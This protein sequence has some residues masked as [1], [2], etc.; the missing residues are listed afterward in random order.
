MTL[1][2]IALVLALHVVVGCGG[3]PATDTPC[4]VDE[5]CPG[6]EVC[7]DLFCREACSADDP[8][9]VGNCHVGDGLCV[10]CVAHE[11][12]RGGELCDFNTFTCD[13]VPRCEADRDCAGGQRCAEGIC[14]AIE[15]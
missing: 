10:E 6:G 8:C 9:E 11:H 3:D 2:R 4:T 12:C 7:H 14:V 1:A 15:R 5:E 13:A